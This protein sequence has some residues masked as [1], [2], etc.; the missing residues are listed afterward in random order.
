M[1]PAQ[2]PHCVTDITPGLHYGLAAEEG[3]KGQREQLAPF[4]V[5]YNSMSTGCLAVAPLD[6]VGGG[7]DPR[8]RAKD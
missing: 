8:R 4:A 3:N 6:S 5:G 1:E 2:L 7:R